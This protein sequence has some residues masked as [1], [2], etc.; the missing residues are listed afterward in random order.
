MLA[1]DRG[2]GKPAPDACET[3][4]FLNRL[5]KAL[6]VT[7]PR[8]VCRCMSL[9]LLLE[10]ELALLSEDMLKERGR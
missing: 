8:R 5:E 10:L 2:V 6:E 4:L 1:V 3:E 9:G 7:E